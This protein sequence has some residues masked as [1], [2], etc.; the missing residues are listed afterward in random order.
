MSSQILEGLIYQQ[1]VML[2]ENIVLYKS[3]Y[4]LDLDELVNKY[5][6]KSNV[7]NTYNEEPYVKEQ[8]QII[9]KKNKK[10]LIIS[11]D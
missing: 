5:L 11:E 10:K 3:S 4:N 7:D 9:V 8:N 2:L 1:Q 6:I